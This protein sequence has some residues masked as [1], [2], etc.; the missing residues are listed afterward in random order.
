MPKSLCPP[1]EDVVPS[2]EEVTST[3]SANLYD[4]TT[5]VMDAIWHRAGVL[6]EE[7]GSV[8]DSLRWQI[9]RL[10]RLE[11]LHDQSKVSV[12]QVLAEQAQAIGDKTFFI[13]HGRAYSYREANRRVGRMAEAL[14][15]GGVRRGQ[16]VGIFMNNHPNYLMAVGAISRLG[17]VSVLINTG[18]RGASL[19]HAM[20][21]GEVDVLLCDWEHLL[22]GR[23]AFSGGKIVLVG[24]VSM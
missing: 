22:V 24:R 13:W 10:A 20:E 1:S 7:V 23:S 4:V 18:A 19:T 16:Y 3:A 2:S 9:P 8:M 6:S 11:S 12:A 14:Y 17:A 21:S 15:A 5:D